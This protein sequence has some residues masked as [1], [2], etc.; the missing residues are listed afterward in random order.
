VN[1]PNSVELEEKIN[2]LDSDNEPKKKIN[3]NK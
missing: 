1:Q 2:K 3:K